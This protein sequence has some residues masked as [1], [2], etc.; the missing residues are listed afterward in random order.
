M[1]DSKIY[2]KNTFE[3]L[4][5]YKIVIFFSLVICTGLSLE[6][7][8]WLKKKYKASFVI[9]VYSKYFANPLVNEV[10]RGEY[11]I[12]QMRFT[13]DSMVKEALDDEY[14]DSIG[15]EY[16]FYANNMNKKQL[17]WARSFLRERFKLFSTGGQSYQVDFFGRDP[18]TALEISQKT[19]KHVKNYFVQTRIMTIE[20]VKKIVMKRIESMNVGQKIEKDGP[21]NP[22]ASMSP[23]VL[24]GELKKVNNEII[25][26][27]KQFNGE[28]PSVLKLEKRKVQL[29][30]WLSDY[31]PEK[32]NSNEDLSLSIMN[33]DDKDIALNLSSRLYIKFNDINMALALEK[34]N[35]PSYIGVIKRPNLPLYPIWPKKRIFASVGLLMGLM[36]AFIYI[37]YHE[38]MSETQVEAIELIAE[39]LGTEFLGTVSLNQTLA[40]NP[41]RDHTIYASGPR[42]KADTLIDNN[43]H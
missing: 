31:K 22:L 27:K 24:Q 36:I 32:S 25:A 33:V 16:S 42:K 10:I 41:P 23:D 40:L 20:N 30:N 14:I 11:S 8:R 34:Q 13:I 1:N 29:E 5:R 7:T 28:H 12:P 9:N 19:L 15:Y 39:E 26:L 37:L 2:I 4:R 17:T 6:T 43:T 35:L 3:I 38:V 18:I 21:A